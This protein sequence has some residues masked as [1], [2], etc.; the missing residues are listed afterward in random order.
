M[1]KVTK[2]VLYDIIRNRFVMGYTLLLAAVSFSFFGFDPDPNKGLLSL[3]NIILMVVPLVSIIF[4][5]I[6][7]YNSYEFIEL[8]SA[9]PLSRR[10][11]FLSEYI[12]VAASLSLAFLV[13]VG[14]PTML[15]EGT[16]RGIVL[17]ISGLL[18]TLSFVSLAFLAAVITRDKAKGMG[19]ALVIWFYF[20][21]VY[22]GL[23]LGIL[24]SFSDYPLEKVML[25]LT[26]LNPTDLARIMVLMKMDISALMG[27][28]GAVFQ[29]FFSTNYGLIIAL[30]A[31]LVWVIWP[32]ALATRIFRKKDL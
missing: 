30:S 14:I 5:T 32:V 21:L 13:G 31:L 24:F 2:Y 26:A 22:D 8:L 28:T 7:F 6:H 10:S 3:L 18:L 11:I 12:G 23:V 1:N 19:L 20:A 29:D 17:I 4:S 27:F 9:Q 15:F 25:F 16:E